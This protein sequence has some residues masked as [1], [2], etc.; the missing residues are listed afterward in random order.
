MQNCIILYI[1]KHTTN[2]LGLLWRSDLLNN[3][4]YNLD[5][6]KS[7]RVDGT[8]DFTSKYRSIAVII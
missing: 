6:S 4:Q 7:V 8:D 3:I 5:V 2:P 1:L